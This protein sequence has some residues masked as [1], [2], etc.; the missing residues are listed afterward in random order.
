MGK[1]S[2]N[3]KQAIIKS[4]ITII[5]SSIIS[6]YCTSCHAVRTMLHNSPTRNLGTNQ[7][8]ANMIEN[9]VANKSNF[10]VIKYEE[11]AKII[12]N[13]IQQGQFQQVE[14]ILNDA[15]QNQ[16]LTR[17]GF[18]YAGSILDNIFIDVQ[19]NLLDY[20]NRW[21]EQYP[22]SSLAYTV[23]A[24]FYYNYAWSI[25]GGNYIQKT[26]EDKI[27]GYLEQLSLCADDINQALKLDPDNPLALLYV[28]RIGRNTN[29][30]RAVFEQYMNK[31]TSVVPYYIRAYQEKSIFLAPNWHGSEAA[32]LNFVRKTVATA[33][34]ETALPLLLPQAHQDLSKYGGRNRRQY[35]NQPQVWNEIEQNFLRLIEDFPRSG[36]YCLWFA[37]MAEDAG[38]EKIAMKYYALALER[39]PN[40]STIQK[41]VLEFQQR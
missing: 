9:H 7:I 37:E 8:N 26:P 17:G 40:N 36:I 23:R 28:L 35:Y 18:L 15:I 32:L 14:Q 13:L 20:L 29:M 22:D 12:V 30:S 11:Q 34:E 39:E 19:P 6:L 38:K 33:P 1:F 4:G 3:P 10:A 27:R 41:K 24:Y 21:I 2:L 25:R 16:T 5:L 31:A